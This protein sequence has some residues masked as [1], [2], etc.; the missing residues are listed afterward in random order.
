MSK[1][2]ALSSALSVLLMAGFVLFGTSAPHA[3]F[4]QKAGV[5]A[6][7]AADAGLRQPGTLLSIVR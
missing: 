1:R 2:L 5:G 6:M 4:E 7:E 3:P